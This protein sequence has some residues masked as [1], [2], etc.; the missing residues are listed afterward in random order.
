MLQIRSDCAAAGRKCGAK[1]ASSQLD[2]Q[3]TVGTECTTTTASACAG[4]DISS[5]VNGV[6]VK[7][8]CADYGLTT[9]GVATTFPICM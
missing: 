1:D 4:N 9:C 7:I 3:P 8:T 2:C 5:C 6:T